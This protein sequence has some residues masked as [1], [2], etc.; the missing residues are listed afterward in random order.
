[1]GHAR[2]QIRP[3]VRLKLRLSELIL[4]LFVQLASGRSRESI[5]VELDLLLEPGVEEAADLE[6][7]VDRRFDLRGRSRPSASASTI[8]VSSLACCASSIQ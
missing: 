8:S 3:A 1:M 4:L 2:A 5:E 7:V 6:V